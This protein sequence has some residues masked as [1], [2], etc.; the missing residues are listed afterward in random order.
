MIG[1]DTNVLL[2]LFTTDNPEQ[3]TAAAK[4]MDGCG[5]SSIRITN[6]VMA[7][8]VWTL[9]GRKYRV[10]KARLVE[11]VEDLLRREELVF[12]SRNAVMMAVRWF[13]GGNADFGDYLIAAL[14]EEAGASPT[15]TFDRMAAGHV[16]FSPMMP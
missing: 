10:E 8:L 3:A 1:I 11:I 5:P 15:Y 12:E 4:L 6:I 7:E 13:E 14:N 16:A 2:R 9:L